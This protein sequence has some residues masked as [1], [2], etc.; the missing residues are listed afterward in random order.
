MTTLMHSGILK[1]FY[2]TALALPLLAC[3]QTTPAKVSVERLNTPSGVTSS[4]FKLPQ[5]AGCSGEIARYKAVVDNDLI[6]GHVNQSVHDRIIDDLSPAQ[7]S[8]T[9][10]REGEALASIKAVKTRF[11][12]PG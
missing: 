7:A 2:V 1:A 3:Q 5:G 11:G 4:N 9:A 10:G 6:T 12:Y 8:C